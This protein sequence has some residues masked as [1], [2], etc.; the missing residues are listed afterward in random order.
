[1]VRGG[2]STVTMWL[3]RFVLIVL[4]ALRGTDWLPCGVMCDIITKIQSIIVLGGV[5]C[6]NK[7]GV[8]ITYKRNGVR[9][10]VVMM[11]MI[12]G[13]GGSGVPLIGIG[14]PFA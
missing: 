12:V 13:A 3:Q 14:G 6:G 9:N 11:Q 2:G 10:V 4:H 7:N 1:M 8:I 5:P